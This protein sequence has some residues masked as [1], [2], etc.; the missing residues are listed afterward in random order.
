MSNTACDFLQEV[1]KFLDL[2]HKDH[3][4]VYNLCSKCLPKYCTVHFIRGN[5]KFHHFKLASSTQCIMGQHA[6]MATLIPYKCLGIAHVA[7]SM[8]L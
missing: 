6:P 7:A 5:R 2:K 1:V 8:S 3:Y 4:K